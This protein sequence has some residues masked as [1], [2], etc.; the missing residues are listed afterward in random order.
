MDLI[1]YEDIYKTY[2]IGDVFYDR[3]LN[4]CVLLKKSNDEKIKYIIY[5]DMSNDDNIAYNITLGSRILL[6]LGINKIKNSIYWNKKL[7]FTKKY[8]EKLMWMNKKQLLI[9]YEKTLKEGLEKR[10][11][12]EEEYK[13]LQKF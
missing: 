3:D 9:D 8:G 10:I 11:I 4:K 12:T 13:T 1:S 2:S 5:N 7:F 6:S